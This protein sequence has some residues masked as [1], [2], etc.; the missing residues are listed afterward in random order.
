MT[1]LS[2]LKQ[3]VHILAKRKYIEAVYLQHRRLRRDFLVM[4]S[5]IRL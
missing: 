4:V 3:T 5:K 2:V 1:E